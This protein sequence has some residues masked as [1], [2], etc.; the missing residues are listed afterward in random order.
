MVPFAKARL[1]LDEALEAG[2]IFECWAHEACFAPIADFALHRHDANPRDHHWAYQHAQRMHR[3]HRASMDRLLEHVRA[4]GP[5]KSSDFERQR[6]G[7]SGWWGWCWTETAFRRRTK[8]S[9]AT[10]RTTRR[11]RTC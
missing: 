1:G 6:K 5:V 7:A 9:T 4:T 11:W 10:A 2:D 8:C 3:E